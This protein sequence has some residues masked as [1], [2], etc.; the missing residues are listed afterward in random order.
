[1][2]ATTNSR[3]QRRRTVGLAAVAA[4]SIWLV[5][6][7]TIGAAT[8]RDNLAAVRNATAAFHDLE[9]AEAAGY[10]PFYVCTDA[11]GVGA[12][13]QHYVNLE[14]VGDPAIDPLRPEAL[15]YEPRPNGGYK[16]VGVEWVTF[17]DAW[18]Q[19]NG[20]AGPSVLGVPMKATP[21]GNRYGLPPFYQRH[22]WIWAPNPLGTF[23]DWN[24]RVT[25][26]GQGDPA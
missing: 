15:V 7:G 2:D 20:S 1:M 13:G 16:L 18:H 19:A 21:A 10:T 25:C 5:A 24:S 23:E 22:A 14:L 9:Q 17:Q 4:L 8:G 11:E 26:R 12:M 3:T 6:A